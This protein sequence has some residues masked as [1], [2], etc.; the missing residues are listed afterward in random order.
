MC[1]Y[2]IYVETINQS[3]PL[4]INEWQ[5]PPAWSCC[6]K[7]KTFFP[8]F[9]RRAAVHRPPIPLP[10]TM[11]SRFS[12]TFRD[13]N[14]CF[15]TLSLAAWSRTRG[16]GVRR[17]SNAKGFAPRLLNFARI[18]KMT[19]GIITATTIDKARKL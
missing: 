10:I 1:Y 7:T 16:S 18:L 15:R 12:G 8:A 19:S 2:F 5:H 6:S 17:Q 4:S 14:P 9:A 3:L 11:A 13:T